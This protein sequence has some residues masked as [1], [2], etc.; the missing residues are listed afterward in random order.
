MPSA[1]RRSSLARRAARQLG[2]LLVGHGGRAYVDVDLGDL[3]LALL[4]AGQRDVDGVAALVADERLAHRR[5]VGQLALRRVGL[6]RADDR[7]LL[8]V[9]VFSSLTLTVTPTRDDVGRQLG[10]VDDLRRA[11]PVLELGDLL[12][13]HHLLVLG[14]VVLR[15]LG[16]VAELA[17]LLDALGD[18][19]TLV[20]L[21]LLELALELLEAFGSEDDVLGHGRFSGRGG[22]ALRYETPLGGGDRRRT[23]R[24]RAGQYSAARGRRRAP[25]RCQAAAARGSRVASTERACCAVAVACM[26][27]W[28]A[29]EAPRRSRYQ[30]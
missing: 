11:Q 27:C 16:D 30:G 4:A 5:L 28:T 10:R 18:L 25:E 22:R 26:A 29:L 2:A 7:V 1:R 12:L 9:A 8:A 15:V 14:V 3:E 17:G 6:S 21:Q 19:A 23:W 20:G 13:E 24:E